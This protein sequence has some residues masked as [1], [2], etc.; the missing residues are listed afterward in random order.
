MNGFGVDA[1]SNGSRTT[2]LGS[3]DVDVERYREGARV[4]SSLPRFNQPL[5]Y[6][7]LPWLFWF[8]RI[9]QRH[10]NFIS[11]AVQAAV[12]SRL[13]SFFGGSSCNCCGCVSKIESVCCCITVS[14][15]EKLGYCV[16]AP[17]IQDLC[18]RYPALRARAGVFRIELGRRWRAAWG[19]SGRRAQP[20]YSIAGAR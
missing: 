20:V 18:F 10:W 3:G 7:S 12:V 6:C 1:V 5:F 17:C 8:L 11:A 15:F 14:A 2:R 4:V 19:R 13:S 9:V 16:T